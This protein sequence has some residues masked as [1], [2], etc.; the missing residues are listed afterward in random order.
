M[1][2][3]I[4]QVCLVLIPTSHTSEGSEDAS[5]HSRYV[6]SAIFRDLDGGSLL[7]LSKDNLK[8]IN[9]NTIFLDSADAFQVPENYFTALND[10]VEA[11]TDLNTVKLDARTQPHMFESNK[12]TK[13]GRIDNPCCLFVS[14]SHAT[15]K[16]SNGSKA[17]H[18]G[19]GY[20][21]KR[22]RHNGQPN[23]Q[24]PKCHL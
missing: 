22:T 20:N 17:T 11:A 19:A 5:L 1:L 3:Y 16:T 7:Q 9:K 10:A 2:T 6:A 13:T 18:I 23:F 14:W 21:I 8:D 15:H 4:G 24:V 12:I